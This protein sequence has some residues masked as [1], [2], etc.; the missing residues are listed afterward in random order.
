MPY[1]RLDPREMILRDHLA[2]DRTVLANE[3]TWLAYVRTALGLLAAGGTV[4]RFFAT[5]P[6]MLYLGAVL[7]AL[8]VFCAVW[9]YYRYAKMRYRLSRVYKVPEPGELSSQDQA[10]GGSGR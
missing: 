5:T 10:A 4:L 6:A 3:R 7:V 1:A 2:Y 9:G 8:G